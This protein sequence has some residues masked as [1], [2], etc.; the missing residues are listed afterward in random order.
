MRL[1]C[2]LLMLLGSA[3]AATLPIRVLIAQGSHLQLQI[4]FV[5]A[6]YYPD[7]TLLYQSTTAVTWPLSLA[8]N[9]NIAVNGTDSGSKSLYFNGADNAT[10]TIGNISYRGAMSFQSKDGRLYAVNVVDIEDY[11]RSV[12]PAEMPA[13]WPSEAIKAQA[14]IARTY[15]IAHLDVND[16]F[17]LCATQQ[18]QV[19]AGTSTEN[20][21]S[22]LAV[23]QTAGKLVAWQDNPAETY[24]ASDNGGFIASSAEVWGRS[25]PYLQAGPDPFSANSNSPKRNW[26]MEVNYSQV[27]NIASSYGISVGKLSRV[28]VS[29][30]SP[31][32]RPAS[33]TFKGSKGSKVLRGAEVG[34]F[35]KSLG[36]W[37]TRVA[38]S[39]SDVLTV[40]GSGFGHGVGLSQW[41]ALDMANQGYT[42]DAIL[43]F[44]YRGASL[45]SYVVAD[46][47]IP[48]L[49]T[50]AILPTPILS[51][52]YNAMH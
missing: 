2:I 9:G 33:I 35:I 20:P 29:K 22:D 38:L 26:N 8:S 25:I 42:F 1:I 44:Y 40:R 39:N 19:Y 15:A 16:F 18:C 5:H 46:Q 23:K 48:Q 27:Q 17:D 14:V 24:F 6:I 30:Y 51:T 43:G 45:S 13:L 10:M 41:G 47:A 34:G 11:L 36:A 49:K 37:S 21:N 50:L 3:S 7:G 28:S 32:G 31:S 52:R 4:P 12:V